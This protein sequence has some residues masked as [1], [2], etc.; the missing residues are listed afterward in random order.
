MAALTCVC[1]Q[2]A[3]NA[4]YSE[5]LEYWDNS[6]N[7]RSSHNC[8]RYK[9]RLNSA[10]CSVIYT[11]N[12]SDWQEFTLVIELCDS[13]CSAKFMGYFSSRRLLTIGS[14]WGE[15]PVVHIKKLDEA[16]AAKDLIRAGCRQAS[17]GAAVLG[18]ERNASLQEAWYELSYTLPRGSQEKTAKKRSQ[19]RTKANKDHFWSCQ[20]GTAK[21]TRVNQQLG[22]QV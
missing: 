4:H 7:H 15:I 17:S 18:D 5:V 9:R 20:N 21:A 10:F 14:F 13:Y 22:P 2:R 8:F 3:T 19:G 11:M 12:C 1:V 16:E 6:Y